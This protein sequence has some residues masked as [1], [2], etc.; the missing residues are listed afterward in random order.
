VFNHAGFYEPATDGESKKSGGEHHEETDFGL[1]FAF[2]TEKTGWSPREISQL[3]FKQLNAYLVA[4]GK[5]MGTKESVDPTV[6]DL[7]KFNLVAGIPKK[8]I[9]KN[10]T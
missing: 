8:L 6:E 9:K 3:T 10:D 7:E 5:Q 1:V 4:W 2:I